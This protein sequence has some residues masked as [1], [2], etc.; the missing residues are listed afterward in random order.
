MAFHGSFS[1]ESSDATSVA[2]SPRYERVYAH[3]GLGA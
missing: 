1:D 2:K 3:E